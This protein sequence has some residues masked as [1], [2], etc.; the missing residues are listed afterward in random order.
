MGRAGAKLAR[1]GAAI[2]AERVHARATDESLIDTLAARS[3]ARVDPESLYRDVVPASRRKRLGQ[4]FTPPSVAELMIRWI[5]AIGPRSVLDPAVGPGIFP[6]LLRRACPQAVVT[7]IDVD[8]VA[9]AAAR[10]ALGEGAKL[11]LVDAD[12]MTWDDATAFD[13]AVANP[14]YLRHHDMSYDFDVHDVVGRR[15]GV[16][17]SR[18]TN[19]YA[20]FILEICRRLRDGGRAAIVVPTEWM[21][22]NFGAPLK[23]WLLGHGWLRTIIYWSH[24]TVPFED[25]LTTASVLLIE[26]D[27]RRAGRTVRA[28]YVTGDAPPDALDACVQ[29]DA[30]RADPRA[31]A[32][33]VVVRELDRASLLLHGKWNDLLEHGIRPAPPGFVRLGELAATRRGIATGANR[34]FHLRP[35]EAARIGLRASSMRPCVGRATDARGCVFTHE[36]YA[37]IA[38]AD[39]R[40]ILLDIDGEPD[41][42]EQAWLA[43]GERDGI[44]ARYLCAARRP[45]WH[46]MERRP[47]API[48]AGVF[49]RTGLR[50]VRNVAGV[51]NLT[52]FHCI[53]P[54]DDDPE[55]LAALTACLAS[56]VVQAE[57]RRH[58]RVYGAGLS[59][60]EPR[61]LLEIA[62]PDLR[63]VA[64]ATRRAL[65]D[66]LVTLDRAMRAGREVEARKRLDALVR[67]AAAEA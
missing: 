49:A 17:L 65:A 44:A 29:E 56:D 25:A 62:V 41:P 47:A 59:K 39:G 54:F 22:A 7:A 14:P 38:A 45:H 18:L 28:I 16:T 11:R 58:V 12:F 21:S 52:A 67:A 24:A 19:L 61:D 42:R 64:R 13:A 2:G 60:I 34:F 8:P 63:G 5:A 57:A 51:A 55:H 3:P 31:A 32:A 43:Q 37:G 48:W 9:L 10:I 26:K 15:N 6:R 46:R 23:E 40:S 27:A 33:G 50:F 36:D 4:Y 35:S 66:A 1:L 30:G 53:Y 20:L